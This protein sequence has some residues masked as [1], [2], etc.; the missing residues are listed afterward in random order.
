MTEL[1]RKD[2]LD[3]LKISISSSLS[4]NLYIAYDKDDECL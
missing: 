1:G 4:F 3:L 2:K